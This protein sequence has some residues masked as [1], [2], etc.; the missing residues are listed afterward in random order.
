MKREYLIG[1]G[2]FVFAIV[3]FA[4]GLTTKSIWYDETLSL[5]IAGAP[6]SKLSFFLHNLSPHPPAYFLFLKPLVYTDSL[7]AWRFLSVILASLG[8]VA[9]FGIFKKRPMVGVALAILYVL[10]PLSLYYAQEIRMYAMEEGLFAILLWS[11]FFYLEEGK[12]FYLIV[13]FVTSILFALTHYFSLLIFPGLMGAVFLYS[14][15]SGNWKRPQRV[16]IALSVGF[17]AVFLWYI[18]SERALKMAE[19][20]GRIWHLSLKYYLSLPA[21]F[22]GIPGYV[23]IFFTVAV[24]GLILY[25]LLRDNRRLFPWLF[26]LIFITPFLVFQLRPPKHWLNPRYFIAMLPLF[27]VA[28]GWLLDYFLEELGSRKKVIMGIGVTIFLLLTFFSVAKD[29][30]YFPR[31]KHAWKAVVRDYVEKYPGA[32][33]V[34][35]PPYTMASLVFNLPISIEEKLKLF[36]KPNTVFSWRRIEIGNKYLFVSAPSFV[37]RREVFSNLES[38]GFPIF[39]ISTVKD[40]RMVP[41]KVYKPIEGKLYVYRL[42]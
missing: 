4:I 12:K 27:L 6:L 28:L 42:N 39:L 25:A 37:F 19:E 23:A 10:A 18:S 32:V 17:L 22:W 35:N 36:K 9:I 8:A 13:L 40:D 20:G 24:V 7:F 29:S 11:L 34:L 26:L 38:K 5:I 31:D 16:L 41:Q 14:I 1:L 15:F 33:F 2:I 30:D 3:F 21:R